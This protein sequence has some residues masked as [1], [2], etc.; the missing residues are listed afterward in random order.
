M[1]SKHYAY[2]VSSHKRLSQEQ[3]VQEN[4]KHFMEFD[5][6]FS[7]SRFGRTLQ[8]QDKEEIEEILN[9]LRQAG[10]PD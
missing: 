10:L 5:P 3:G 1:Q 4:A 2:L 8:Y 6:K 7:I 9:D